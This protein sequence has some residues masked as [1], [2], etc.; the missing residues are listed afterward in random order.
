MSGGT[1][2]VVDQQRRA[3]TKT[4]IDAEARKTVLR[5]TRALWGK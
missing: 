5:E 3:K 4:V 2:N 1:G